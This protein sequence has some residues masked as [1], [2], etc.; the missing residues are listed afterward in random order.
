MNNKHFLVQLLIFIFSLNL[1][2]QNN[3]D[4]ESKFT[5]EHL[6]D[7]PAKLIPFPQEFEW[8]EDY[9]KLSEASIKFENDNL[10]NNNALTAEMTLILNENKINVS[11]DSSVKVKFNFDKKIADE[12]YRLTVR[13]KGVSITSSS[14]SGSYYALQTLR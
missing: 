3:S 7:A 12:G 10:Q 6:K 11:S 4:F 13:K 2:A 14:E 8:D 5:V 1:L 9:L